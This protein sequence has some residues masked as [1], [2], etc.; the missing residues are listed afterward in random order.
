MGVLLHTL[1]RAFWGAALR[2]NGRVV[3]VLQLTIPQRRVFKEECG[4]NTRVPPN[5][6]SLRKYA[7][8][9][10][11]FTIALR[12]IAREHS[13]TDPVDRLLQYSMRGGQSSGQPYEQ[14][15]GKC[16]VDLMIRCGN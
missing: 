1:C 5:Q 15:V 13:R 7:G 4:E 2:A 11:R 8:S 12:T 3:T 9:V 10:V 16:L 6:D 14:T